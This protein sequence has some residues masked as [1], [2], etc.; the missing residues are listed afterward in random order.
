MYI[1]GA[2]RETSRVAFFF[3]GSG[4]ARIGGARHPPL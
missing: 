4:D 2:S 3:F 1:D